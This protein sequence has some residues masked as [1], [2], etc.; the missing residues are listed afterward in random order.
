MSSCWEKQLPYARNGAQ[1]CRIKANPFPANQRLNRELQHKTTSASLGQAR[2]WFLA[3]DRSRRQGRLI[4]LLGHP[5]RLEHK[6]IPQKILVVST[7]REMLPPGEPD[8]GGVK[9]TIGLQ[10]RLA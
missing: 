9:E 7:P 2:R 6:N 5:P 3:A 10:P 4:A 8:W 1:S